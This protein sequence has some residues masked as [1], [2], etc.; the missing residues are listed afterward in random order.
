MLLSL[1]LCACLPKSPSALD[2]ED[3]WE[4]TLEQSVPGVVALRVV[5]TRSFDTETSSSSVGTGFVIDAERGLILTNRHMVHAGPVRAEAVFLNHEEVPLEAI[6]RDP[7]HDFGLYRFDPAD[8]RHMELVELSLHPEAAQVGAEIRV[9]GN[10]AGEKIVI[11][12]GTLARLDR[13]APSYG[14]N[15]YND[16]NTFYLQAG[17]G[18]SG[19]SSGSPVLD[20]QGRVIGLNAG[21]SKRSASSYYLPLDR[22]VRAVELVQ[23][24]QPVTRGTLQATFEHQP[25]DELRRLGMTEATESRLRET[26]PE[27]HGALVVR[28]LVPEGPVDGLLEPGDILLEVGGQLLT[29]FVPLE[30]A[31]DE[32]VGQPI[33]LV[34]ERGG[35]RLE[36]EPTVGDLHAISPSAYL[37]FGGAVVHPLSYQQAR[38]HM[39]PARGLY[40]ASPGY[41]LIRAGIPDNAVLLSV[42]GQPVPDLA[43]LETALA[44]LAHG[45]R[46]T[47]RYHTISDPRHES[48]AVIEMDRLWHPMRLCQRDDA[49]GQWPCAD[50]PAPPQAQPPEPG[51]ARF[52]TSANGPAGSLASSL[53]RVD[54]DV[55]LRTEGVSGRNFAGSGLIVDT[56][57]GLVLT[58]RDTVPVS[59]AEVSLTFGGQLRVPAE[60]VYLHPEHNFAVLRYDP[61]LLGD[62]PVKSATLRADELSPGE[63]LWV[64]GLSRDGKVVGRE[65]KVERIDPLTLPLP[66]PPQFREANLEVID[67]TEAVSSIGGALTDSR[68]RV[69]ALWASFVWQGREGRDST[70]RGLPVEHVLEVLEPL[71]RGESPA[72]RSLG[73]EL[74]S[75]SLA[76]ARDRGLSEERVRELAEADPERRKALSIV[77]VHADTPAASLLEDGDLLVAV[78]GQPVTRFRQVELA[79]RSEQVELVVLRDGQELT[80]TV[81]TVLLP[82][83]GIDRVVHFSG[84]LLHEPHREVATQRGLEPQ[85]LYIAT[86]QYGSPAQRFGLRATWRIVEIDGQPTDDLGALLSVIEGKQDGEA[87]RITVVDLDEKKQV[88]TLKLDLQYW[89]TRA[90]TRGDQGWQ[91]E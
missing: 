90:Y 1:L 58:D 40:V 53:V 20:V 2:A 61:A 22:I 32:G 67:P 70:F 9:V 85:G 29:S 44:G 66:T 81:P 48:V 57:R 89:P 28:G 42:D 71:A 59:L 4:E 87:L 78:Q 36:L 88:V 91:L 23:A 34:V 8:V 83:L 80:L 69:V 26:F 75:L 17:S 11:L 39:I 79:A 50:S 37:E 65:A 31:L 43:S 60:V 18:T 6:Y 86:Y 74:S 27:G 21:G 13:E 15:T 64:V 38:N 47:V 35:Q 51:T 16:F 46:A 56:E 76:D 77:R 55:P 62:S 72:L 54:C 63:D 41:T 10:D 12:D 7:V 49:T 73:V 84:M 52:Q 33:R 24:G 45:Q 30:A 5:G 68:G 3:R 82:D 25:Y 14:G 19:G